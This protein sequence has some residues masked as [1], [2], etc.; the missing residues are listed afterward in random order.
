MDSTI[1]KKSAD[2]PKSPKYA[3]I[4]VREESPMEPTEMA[5][6]VAE[7][8]LLLQSQIDALKEEL[9]DQ[10][11]APTQ[12]Q[13]DLKLFALESTIRNDRKFRDQSDEWKR[14]IQAKDDAQDILQS[15][16]SLVTQGRMSA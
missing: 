8:I 13:L 12:K 6:Q 4:E 2:Y 7:H 9:L 10:S 15:L 16:H 14:A 5:W 11:N 1:P 3:A